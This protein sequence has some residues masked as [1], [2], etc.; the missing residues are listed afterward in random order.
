MFH[1]LAHKHHAD[2]PCNRTVG[3]EDLY[4]HFGNGGHMQ[5]GAGAGGNVGALVRSLSSGAGRRVSAPGHHSWCSS[6][7]S[8]VADCYRAHTPSRTSRCA[9]LPRR[10]SVN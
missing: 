5:A 9:T 3:R 8:S 4:N 7:Q 2:I 1:V 10:S 6:S